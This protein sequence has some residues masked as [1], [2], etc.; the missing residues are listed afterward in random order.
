MFECG[1]YLYMEIRLEYEACVFT[2]EEKINMYGCTHIHIRI[3]TYTH[4]YIHTQFALEL[5]GAREEEID[6]LKTTIEEQREVFKQTLQQHLL[7]SG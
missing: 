3:H 2:C 1:V 5:L 4:T 7:T 6:D